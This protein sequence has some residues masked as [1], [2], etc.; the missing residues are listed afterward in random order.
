[1]Q[2][3]LP[4]RRAKRVGSAPVG[5]RASGAEKMRDQI[6]LWT[7]VSPVK[8]AR[9][10]LMIQNWAIDAPNVR[11]AVK[12]TRTLKHCRRCGVMIARQACTPPRASGVPYVHLVLSPTRAKLAASPVPV[13]ARA[14]SAQPVGCAPAVPP[15]NNLTRT[16]PIAKTAQLATPVLLAGRAIGV[17]E[18]R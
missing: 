8:G 12:Q 14:Y 1:M 13:S 15:A 17:P 11:R 6:E 4:V 10:A 7:T 18:T 3:P 16:R 2:Q 9:I 5:L